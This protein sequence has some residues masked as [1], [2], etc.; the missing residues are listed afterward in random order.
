VSEAES[1]LLA[2][3]SLLAAGPATPERD[4]QELE[5]QTALG[6]LLVSR[7]FGAPEREQPLR[8]AY[9]LR[10][11]IGDERKT[12]SVLFQLGQFY[13]QQARFNEARRVADRAVILADHAKDPI[14]EA[15]AQEMLGECCLWIGD[16]RAARP[17]VAR[18]LALCQDLSATA[19]IR[20][21]GF[22]LWA[23]LPLLL[24]IVDLLLGWPDRGMHVEGRAI[25]RAQSSSHPY[26]HALGLV[27][28]AL[29]RWIRGDAKAVS[30]MLIPARQICGNYGFHELAGL[31][32]QI[33]GW[34]HFWQ[35]ERVLGLAEMSEAIQELNAVGANMFAP[36]R[37]ILLAEMQLEGGDTQ[38]AETLLKQAI[39][40][41][42]RTQEGWY[43]PEVYRIASKVILKQ[44]DQD[45]STAEGCLRR[46]I[47]AARAKNAKW[48]ELRSSVSLA[49][50]LRD[51]SH[52]DEARTMLAEIYNWFTEGFDTADLKE[53]KALLDELSC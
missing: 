2:A 4:L 30:E 37:S 29:H 16:V 3:L 44:R 22:D 19:L 9:E 15:G 52:R 41:L 6:A 21:Y 36:Y 18:A 47:K 28:A 34:S 14:L 53:A 43:E 12:I 48:W 25:E 11:R 42:G 8:R 51:S 20:A 1:Q 13:I 7:S 33:D 39:E 10:E 32:K 45:P 27:V 38:A 46:A 17:C 31:A 49:R 40:T 26:S 50:V 23:I 35:G 5:L 24:G